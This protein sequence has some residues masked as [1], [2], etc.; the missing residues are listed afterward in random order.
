[1]RGLVT[2]CVLAAM[3][4]TAAA[5]SKAE[6]TTPP[7]GTMQVSLSRPKVALGSP[8]EVTY[9]FTRRAERAEPW[10]SAAC[11]CTSSTRTKS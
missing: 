2:A 4:V 11:S 9:K 3:A 6:D 10:A 1:M 8:V 7:V 5:C